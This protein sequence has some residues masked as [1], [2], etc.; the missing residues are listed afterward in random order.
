MS[1]Q[2][3]QPPSKRRMISSTIEENNG[4]DSDVKQYID[5][6]FKEMQKQLQDGFEKQMQGIFK[7]L[8]NVNSQAV[9]QIEATIED[10]TRY[11]QKIVEEHLAKAID[12]IVE[13][14]EPRHAA[15]NSLENNTTRKAASE[16][17]KET[18]FPILNVSIKKI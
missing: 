11:T 4:I 9:S 10:S 18:R 1:S 14:S 17:I 8:K 5:H 7:H 12:V 15:N 3:N 6:K 13:S 16:K 2:P